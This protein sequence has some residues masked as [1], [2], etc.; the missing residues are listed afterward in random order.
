MSKKLQE[1]QRR[2]VAEQM[3]RDQHRHAARRSNLITAGIAVLIIGAVT[4]LILTKESDDEST[5]APK[6]VS[7]ANAGCDP[8]E[9]HDDEGHKHVEAGTDVAYETT[10]PTSGNHWLTANVADPGFYPSEVPEESLVHNMEHGQIV[11]WYSPDASSGTVDN[12]EALAKNANDIDNVPSGPGPLI[13]VPYPSVPE[14][15]TFVL[16][17]WTQSQACSQYSLDAINDFREKFQGRGPEPVTAPFAAE[18]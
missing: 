14:G 12:L 4:T 13:V 17:G 5:P 1:K 7:A 9:E 11:I 18:A 6:G 8:I 2:R 16:T 15:K 3:R 10:P